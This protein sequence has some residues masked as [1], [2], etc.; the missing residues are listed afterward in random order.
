MNNSSAFDIINNN[1]ENNNL[2]KII[3]SQYIEDNWADRISE[4]N[5][6]TNTQTLSD[7]DQIVRYTFLGRGLSLKYSYKD[8]LEAY[9][10]GICRL[11]SKE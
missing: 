11:H 1:V 10:K 8:S 7:Y 5:E 4:L 2:R 9:E 3:H 6:I